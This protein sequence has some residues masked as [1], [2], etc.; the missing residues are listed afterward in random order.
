MVA[1]RSLLVQC[2]SRTLSLLV[3]PTLSM[4]HTLLESTNAQFHNMAADT[5]SDQQSQERGPTANG[6]V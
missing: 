5:V 6:T 2:N 4:L 1:A 3:R